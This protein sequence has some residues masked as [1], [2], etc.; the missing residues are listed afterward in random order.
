MKRVIYFL[1]AVISILS[2]P[3]VDE[4]SNKLHARL[5]GAGESGSEAL[6]A[7]VRAHRV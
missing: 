1:L 7:A 5:Y 4:S 3:F 2:S 6:R